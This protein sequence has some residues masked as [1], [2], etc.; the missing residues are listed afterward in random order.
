MTVLRHWGGLHKDEEREGDQRPLEEELLRER[1]T[2]Q[3]GIV[4]MQPRQRRRTESVG[5]RI[6]RPYAPTGVGRPV[7]ENKTK[8]NFEKWVEIPATTSGHL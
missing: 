8:A 3:G 7:D 6:R 4:G 2:R 1:E 5:L